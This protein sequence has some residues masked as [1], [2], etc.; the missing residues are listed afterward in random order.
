MNEAQTRFDKINPKLKQCGWG[1][2]KESRILVEQNANKLTNGK[3]GSS[4]SRALKVDYILVY[5]DVKLAII[6]AKS[7]E[8]DYGEGVAQAKLYAQMMNIRFTYATNGDK[9]YEIDMFT[10]IED[11]IVSYPTPEELWNNTY[12]EIDNWKEKL[13]HTTF[14]TKVDKSPRYYQENAVNKVLDAISEKRNRILLTLATGTGKTFIAFQIAWKLYHTKWNTK[15]EDKRPRILFL[16][17]RNILANQ[18][19]TDFGGFDEK[20][21]LRITPKTFRE[22]KHVPTAQ[23]IYFTIFSTFMT[24]EGEPSY[25]KYPDDF[26]DLIIIDEC[27]RGGA[28]DESSWRDI[29]DYFSSAVQL[30]LTAT[31]KRTDNVNTYEYFGEPVYQY[32]LKQGIEDG[33]LTPFRHVVMKTTIDD[34]IYCEDDDIIDGE[35]LLDK[36]KVYEENDFYYGRIEIEQRD[37]QRV[38]ELLNEINSNDKT[39]VF[40]YNQSHAA[41]IRDMI[42][43][44]SNSKNPNYC[45]RVTANDGNIG[46]NYLRQFQD[47]ENLIPTILTTSH[48]LSTGVDARNI[49]NIVLMRPIN[50]MIEFKQIIG[51]GTRI[52]DNKLYFSILDFVKAYEKYQ[53]PQWDGE[54]I[55]PRCNQVDCICDGNEPPKVCRKCGQKPCVCEK[56]TCEICGH[57]PC[58]CEKEPCEICGEIPCVCKKKKIVIKLSDNREIEVS[59]EYMFY[60]DDG[61]PISTKDFIEKIFGSLPQYFNSKE[62]LI[63]IWA[64]P[65]SREELLNKLEIAGFGVD[66]LTAL[67]EIINVNESDLL[68]VLE[69]IAYSIEPIKRMDRVEENKDSIYSNLNDNQKDFVDFLVDLY[70]KAGVSQLSNSNIKDVINMKYNSL[71]DAKKNFGN[72]NSIKEIFTNFQKSLYGDKS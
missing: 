6:E 43:R 44:L 66:K 24:P 63:K 3:I 23:N 67:Q 7:D 2:V 72:I 52:F 62:E 29:L 60:G 28:N 38:K 32:S 13:L 33:F 36:D 65:L 55:C 69:F 54:P 25:K 71:E 5:K 1:V 40:C 37:E 34:Y 39:L 57:N 45:V 17:D 26:F 49:R 50:S 22:N 21:C 18:A 11:E 19:Q 30:G 35:D 31:P 68:D 48:K 9:I 15:N 27:H 47:N 42:N 8:K 61:K 64:N 41:K 14:F 16:A 70:I 20:L 10:G 56:D 4:S 59:K 58:V 46:E 51:R 12:R 53:D